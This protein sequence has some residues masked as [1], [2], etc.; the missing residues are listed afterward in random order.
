MI[1]RKRLIRTASSIIE[2]K[3]SS[4]LITEIRIRTFPIKIRKSSTIPAIEFS[5]TL[6]IR[7]KRC[8][9]RII[10]TPI[11]PTTSS[12]IA[13]VI[14]RGVYSGLFGIINFPDKSRIEIEMTESEH[15][16]PKREG[17]V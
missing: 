1:M 15:M 16:F 9:R 2:T 17:E 6:A 10:N 4:K 14:V 7:V 3:F 5:F 13:L 8:P 11:N 12:V